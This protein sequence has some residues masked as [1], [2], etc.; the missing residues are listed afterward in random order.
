MSA[1]PSRFLGVFDLN[2]PLQQL[3]LSLVAASAGGVLAWEISPLIESLVGD[4]GRAVIA[5]TATAF[6]LGAMLLQQLL[7]SMRLRATQ[8]DQLE[9]NDAWLALHRKYETAL[10]RLSRDFEQLP[11]FVKIANGHLRN[12]NQGSE[13]GVIS[14]MQ[15]LGG[16]REQSEHLLALLREQE[17]KAGDIAAAQAHRGA[18]NAQTLQELYTYQCEQQSQ[19]SEDSQRVAEVLARVKGLAA[20]TQI[21]RTIARQTNL[22]ALNAAI[23]AA[24][25]GE[26]GRGFAVV[27]DEVRKLSLE[28]ES[29]TLRIDREI[30]D[31]GTLVDQNLTA[32]V[33]EARTEDTMRRINHIAEEFGRMNQD[34]SEVGGYLSDV[35]TH[36]RAAMQVVYDDIVSALGHMQFQDVSRQQIE[37]V[38]DT[39]ETLGTHF[40]EVSTA[41]ST[42]VDPDWRPLAEHIEAFRARHVMNSQRVTHDQVVGRVAMMEERPAIELF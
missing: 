4:R 35:T 11:Q 17:S 18:R 40:E 7:F 21:I 24:R 2:R 15:A 34:F 27:A 29:A 16:V 22:L 32:I 36:T 37:H 9:I 28:T 10:I 30:G 13:E 6:A 41:L 33:S 12:A 39:L 31:L 3:A 1:G 42:R 25:A 38:T 23:E 8:R 5:F 26:A 19:I 20:M 14:I